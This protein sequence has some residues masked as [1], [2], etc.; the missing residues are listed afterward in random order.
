MVEDRTETEEIVKRYIEHLSEHI[1]LFRVYLFGSR[2]RPDYDEFADIDVAVISPDLGENLY[3]E[4]KFLSKIALAIDP[5]IEP[6]PYSM[7]QFNNCSP[8][9]LL[10]EIIEHG[11]LL[12]DAEKKH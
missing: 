7:E 1:E 10:W 3:N 4:M 5:N 2:I 8:G 9:S 6:H 12:Y 11:Y